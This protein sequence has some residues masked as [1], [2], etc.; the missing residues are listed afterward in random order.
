MHLCCLR[1]SLSALFNPYKVMKLCLPQHYHLHIIRKLLAC[2]S[3]RLICWLC[4]AM[5]VGQRMHTILR[6]KSISR[7]IWLGTFDWIGPIRQRCSTCSMSIDI[8]LM[9]PSSCGWQVSIFLLHISTLDHCPD[10]W[11]CSVWKMQNVLWQTPDGEFLIRLTVASYQS[12]NWI[13]VLAADFHVANS[14][15]TLQTVYV[16]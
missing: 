16:V 7:D 2:V 8:H 11:S 12:H 1:S 5:A 10:C 3:V 15:C 6:A 14:G 9:G 13:T 4:L